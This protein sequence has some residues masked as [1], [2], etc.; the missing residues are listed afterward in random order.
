[1]SRDREAVNSLR[2]L[3]DDL[4]WQESLIEQHGPDNPHRNR[5]VAAWI[6]IATFLSEHFPSEYA[7][8]YE[9]NEKRWERKRAA[10]AGAA[11]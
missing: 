6:W 3:L 7:V 10:A 11:P 9:D 8:A 5:K 1:M 4:A 2:A